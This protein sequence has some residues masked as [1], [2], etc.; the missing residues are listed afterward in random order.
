MTTAT[1][2]RGSRALRAA[3][4]AMAEQTYR[5]VISRLRNHPCVSIALSCCGLVYWSPDVDVAVKLMLLVTDGGRIP[6]ELLIADVNPNWITPQRLEAGESALQDCISQLKD[7]GHPFTLLGHVHGQRKVEYHFVPDSQR[8]ALSTIADAA[9]E[10][11]R[12]L[13]RGPICTY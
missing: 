11:V 5:D 7:S 4:R 3:Q 12:C 6:E 8:F 1:H 13:G 9:G 2:S 10:E